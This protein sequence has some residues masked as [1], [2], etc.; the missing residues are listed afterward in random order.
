[1]L[2][3]HTSRVEPERLVRLSFKLNELLALGVETRRVTKSTRGKGEE[4]V[5]AGDFLIDENSVEG[6][7]G[8]VRRMADEVGLKATKILAFDQNSTSRIRTPVV[9]LYSGY[10]T[11]PRS[12]I[13]LHETLEA[14]GFNLV[15]FVDSRDLGSALTN[16][17]LLVVPGGDSTEIALSIGAENALS[18]K[19]FVEAG[20]TY[21]GICA[22]AFLGI[23][24]VAG[25]L[26]PRHRSFSSC[27]EVLGAVKA[28]LVN[29]PSEVPRV[30]MWSYRNYEAVVRLYPYEGEMKFK[31]KKRSD[32]LT[33]GLPS[34]FLL[35]ME[36][37]VFR[38]KD[39]ADVLV[40]SD[41]IL[42]TTTLG[43]RPSGAESLFEQ[44]DA[45]VRKR[46]GS[47]CYVLSSPHIE[48]PGLHEGAVLI[49][50]ILFSAV[51]GT[52]SLSVPPT[53]QKLEARSA[54]L[55][56]ASI[57]DQSDELSR[58]MQRLSQY[59][60]VLIPLLY[61]TASAR[62]SQNVMALSDMLRCLTG[63]SREL[64]QMAVDVVEEQQLLDKLLI[65]LSKGSSQTAIA[66]NAQQLVSL[67]NRVD[68]ERGLMIA[69]AGRALPALAMMSL[70]L[71]KEAT[72]LVSK[73]TKGEE[74]DV[75]KETL[76]LIEKIQGGKALFVPWYDGR[77]GFASDEPANQGIVSPLMG[78]R[79]KMKHVRILSR[80]TRLAATSQNGF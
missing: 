53:P 78:V 40:V 3:I 39:S 13:E 57:V 19:R 38:I 66:G 10:G 50:N 6:A 74:I 7:S 24:S 41:G 52:L 14:T 31:P 45:I 55:L 16:L 27:Q 15:S 26:G 51:S 70:R 12:L 47:G 33:M 49:S 61:G 73:L 48:Q 54:S 46:L 58:S 44:F 22:G 67:V 68:Q 79:A 35:R 60:L 69:T 25:T 2:R 71:E 42:P 77:E 65:S 28:Q 32:P 1:M 59:L 17:D 30:P 18:V 20:G 5:T 34:S 21:V 11:S 29:E 63:E 23:S 8:L 37:P 43:V 62:H 4:N 9:G 56:L 76:I 75:L 80:A 36:G 72:E 64:G